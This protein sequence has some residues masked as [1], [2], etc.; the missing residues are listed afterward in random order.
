[1]INFFKNFFSKQFFGV[2]SWWG[3]R[4]GVKAS[5]IRLFFI[6]ASFAHAITV[7]IYLSMVF[8]L[9]VRNHFKYR[10]R[11]SVFDL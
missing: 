9:K 10:K 5:F 8:I 6:Y 4:L 2:S 11:K 1:M 3:N 7:L